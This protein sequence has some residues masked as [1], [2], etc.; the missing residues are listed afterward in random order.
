MFAIIGCLTEKYS[1]PINDANSDYRLITQQSVA[2]TVV[3][4]TGICYYDAESEDNTKFV[5]SHS[6]TRRKCTG[7]YFRHI[8]NTMN[9]RRDY[10]FTLSLVAAAVSL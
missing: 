8:P 5:R 1:V 2:V 9:A 3:P 6:T 7:S 4:G 10:E